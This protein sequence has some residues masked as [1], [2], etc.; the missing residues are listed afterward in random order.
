VNLGIPR[1]LDPVTRDAVLAALR[2]GESIKAI[3]LYRLATG[4]GL[5]EAK[6]AVDAMAMQNGI[7]SEVK[8]A[9]APFPLSSI[10]LVIVLIF[11]AI[12]I[13]ARGHR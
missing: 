6:R 8:A 4:A 3:R 7:V 11:V 1:I 9:G 13:A 2:G 12:A 5:S 10:L